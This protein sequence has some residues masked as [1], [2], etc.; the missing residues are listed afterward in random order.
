MTNLDALKSNSI[1][2]PVSENTF[3]RILIDRGLSPANE[4]VGKS[5]GME[6][7]VADLYS[8]LITAA[9]VAEG[10]FQVSL[11]EKANFIKLASGIYDKYD[12]PNPFKEQQPAV[13]GVSPW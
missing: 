11:T 5:R 2:Y 12:E 9:N 4:Y 7:A 8:N 1:G 13:K 6:L 10:G 3:L